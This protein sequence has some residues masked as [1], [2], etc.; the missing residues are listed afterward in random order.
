MCVRGPLVCSYLGTK[1]VDCFCGQQFACWQAY[2]FY[3]SFCCSLLTTVRFQTMLIIGCAYS[4]VSVV[5]IQVYLLSVRFF[6][7]RIH[8]ALWPLV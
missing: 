1:R 8:T 6:M 5:C 7:F 4:E 3:L 2:R